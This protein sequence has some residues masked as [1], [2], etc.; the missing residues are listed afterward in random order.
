MSYKAN[1]LISF[2]T[3]DILQKT[4]IRWLLFPFHYTSDPMVKVVNMNRHR[5]VRLGIIT[6]IIIAVTFLTNMS[7][8]DIPQVINY[9]GRLTDSIGL[10]VPDGRHTVQFKI[11]TTAEG[12][13]FVLWDS[14]PQD[15]DTEQGLFTYLLG[16]SVPLGSDL[17]S[18]DTARWL[19]ITVDDNPEGSPRVKLASLPYAFH[20]L[21]S[22]TSDYSHQAPIPYIAETNTVTG[23]TGSIGPEQGTFTVAFDSTYTRP[24]IV[25]VTV[26][27]TA[28][29]GDLTK[30]SLAYAEL[31]ISSIEF[32]VTVYEKQGGAIMSNTAIDVSYIALQIGR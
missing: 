1:S 3:A 20:A 29:S 15:V 22:D 31:S 6:N 12:P 23:I 8:A 16:S 30:G 21:R 27:L 25:M 7:L 4:R 24:P 11:W 13:G 18:S 32:T 19:G 17:F 14:G 2:R 9:Q 5:P 26:V 10:P 28:P